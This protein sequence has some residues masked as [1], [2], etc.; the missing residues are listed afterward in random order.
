MDDKNTRIE[1]IRQ[2]IKSID[3]KTFENKEKEFYQT[4]L[5]VIQALTEGEDVNIP[6]EIFAEM[7]GDLRRI[8]L[9]SLCVFLAFDEEDI[10]E[11]I[12]RIGRK[13]K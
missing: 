8:S 11:S 5:N 7:S 10:L 6:H 12:A 1:Y 9:F 3:L 4:L 13:S 2:A